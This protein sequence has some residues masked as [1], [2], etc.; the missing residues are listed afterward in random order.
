MLVLSRKPNEAILIGGD[1]EIVILETQGNTVRLGIQAPREIPVVRAEL[2]QKHLAEG[3]QRMRQDSESPANRGAEI[4]AVNTGHAQ[5]LHDFCERR[6][7][8]RTSGI[9][10]VLG[11]INTP[12]EPEPISVVGLG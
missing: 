7:N 3:R 6:R 4:H 8:W 5:L 2:A 9:A 10:E 1:I 11:L 12:S